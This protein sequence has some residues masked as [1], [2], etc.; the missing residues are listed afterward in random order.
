[1]HLTRQL[2]GLASQP[3]ISVVRSIMNNN[4]PLI[5]TLIGALIALIPAKILLR[6]DRQSGYRLYKSAPNEEI[7]LKRAKLFYRIFGAILAIAPWI[8]FH[9]FY[10][11]GT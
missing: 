10:K 1:M 3:V 9:F 8:L 6:F 4:F 7:G 11:T 2:T 5:L